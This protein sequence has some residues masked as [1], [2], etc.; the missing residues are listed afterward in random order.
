MFILIG[1][2]Q[3]VINKTKEALIKKEGE[4]EED[5]SIKIAKVNIARN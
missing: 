4:L 2:S 3:I 5:I 1:L